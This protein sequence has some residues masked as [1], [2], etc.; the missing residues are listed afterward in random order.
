MGWS[1]K[2]VVGRAHASFCLACLYCICLRTLWSTINPRAACT[3]QVQ[4]STVQDRTGQD[5]P[6]SIVISECPYGVSVAFGGGCWLA[7]VVVVL[8]GERFEVSD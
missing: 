7:V 1:W 8:D 6:V 3:I 5:Q 4:Y 2:N